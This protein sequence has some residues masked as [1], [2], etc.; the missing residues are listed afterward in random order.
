MTVP[1]EGGGDRVV[2]TV[3]G[4]VL[5]GPLLQGRDFTVHLPP[6]ITPALAG[7]P[8]PSPTFTGRGEA[9]ER[10]LADL[11]PAA[12]A[13]GEDSG[14][15]GQRPVLVTAVAGLAGIGKTELAVQTAARALAEPGWFPGGV[16]FT[17]LSGYHPDP[18]QR[19]TPERALEGLLRALAV[20]GEH[21]PGG[22]QD[23]RRLYRSALAAYAAE[24]RRLLVVV[25]NASDSAQ[26]RPLLPTD[27]VT[28]ALVTSRHTLDGLGA[29][30]HDLD[31]LDAPASTVLLD[32]AL[33]HARGDADSRFT[34]D[35]AGTAVIA[36]LCAGLPLA[37]HIAAALLAVAPHR[38]AAS[39]AAALGE[40]H[41]R[42]GTLT[43]PDRAVR[44]AFDLSYDVLGPAHARLFRLLPLAPGPDL[45]TAAAAHLA[46]TDTAA[47]EALLQ[48]LAE[49]HLIETSRDTW[50]RWRMHDLV[51]LYADERGGDRGGRDGGG[52]ADEDER[53][54]AR[55][56]LYGYY[57]RT[58][59]AAATHVAATA[60]NPDP[61]FR[62]RDDALRW[63]DAEHPNLVA[64]ATAAAG[65]GDRDATVELT[66]DLAEYL[67][68]RRYFEDG[69]ALAGITLAV[70][71][72][73]G[74]RRCEILALGILG[75][76]LRQMRRFEEAIDT[77]EQAAA[78]CEGIGDRGRRS[79][80]LGNLGAALVEARRFDEAIDV[81]TEAVAYAR[82]VGD[83]RSGAIALSNLGAAL[84]EVRRFEE[85]IDVLTEVVAYAREV[86]D[87]LF[88][89]T[90]LN[91][92]AIPLVKSG[93]FEESVRARTRAVDINR[94][95]GDRHGE[96][97]ALGNLGADLTHMDRAG[98]AIG[99]LGA[100]IDTFRDL[101][102]RY[103]EGVALNVLGS[104]L[105]VAGRFEET[106]RVSERAVALFRDLGDRHGE[107]YALSN[108][109]AALRQAGRPR[110]A[111]AV[112]AG[113]IA[114][115]RD[116]GDRHREGLVA[117][118]LAGALAEACA[119]PPV[120]AAEAG[121]A[122]G[123]LL[124]SRRRLSGEDHPDTYVARDRT[125]YY[126][127]EAGDAAGAAGDLAGL[128]EGMARALGPDHADVEAVRAHHAHWVARAA[129]SPQR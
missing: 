63:L 90:A 21:I 69:Y 13:A 104:A 20:P 98:E 121:A 123:E 31:M 107:C 94:H 64:A 93:R 14:G 95:L 75:T 117:D 77:Q 89:G 54:A 53:P 28:A 85:A 23:R 49:A 71:R 51:R 58:T 29:R 109:G 96:S 81:L 44:A 60:G 92:L 25:D 16:L 36:R 100:A 4:G 79:Q 86:G 57:R 43:R 9:V 116:L 39:L 1:E 17:D 41:L 111:V 37:L 67:D 42:L 12:G 80:A 122:Y 5:F 99:V 26:A 38:S 83:R 59:R 126:R 103:R 7:L 22:L 91:N 120:D 18:D 124:A 125:A 56:R 10:L 35:P 108:H 8:A 87:R 66:F 2:N 46:G 19:V 88:E 15:G 48:H 97:E 127:G 40:E 52:G 3:S 24:G 129:A 55:A 115:F 6:R 101:G 11:A 84:A 27:G 61:R 128:L 33:R 30:L 65:L 78:M 82:E 105:A 73:A 76:A 118:M 113:A 70:S 119:R 34:D 112:L 110:E 47:A 114:G 106:L 32:Q 74:D 45:S 50:G 72:E 68:Q 62:D 102:D